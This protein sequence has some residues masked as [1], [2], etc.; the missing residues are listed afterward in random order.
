VPAFSNHSRRVVDSL[1]VV[2]FLSFLVVYDSWVFVFV[3]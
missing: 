3:G 2:C 1:S